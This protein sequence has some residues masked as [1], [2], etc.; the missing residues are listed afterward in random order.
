VQPFDRLSTKAEFARS[1]AESGRI[2][3]QMRGEVRLNGLAID[4]S[5]QAIYESREVLNLSADAQS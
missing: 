4:K 1:I 3:G 2:M 5:R